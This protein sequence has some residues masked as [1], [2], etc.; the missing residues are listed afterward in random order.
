MNWINEALEAVKKL[1]L[2]FSG[3]IELHWNIDDM[4]ERY[5]EGDDGVRRY[6]SDRLYSYLWASKLSGGQWGTRVMI[7]LSPDEK[8]LFVMVD[9]Y[10]PWGTGEEEPYKIATYPVG[11]I[12]QAF[13]LAFAAKESDFELCGL[14]EDEDS[15]RYVP[16]PI[17]LPDVNLLLAEQAISA[18]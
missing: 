7:A 6:Y 4:S 16:A 15:G 8:S 10:Q 3:A 13:K 12:Y 11:E 14:M 17:R 1:S 5:V 18:H 9:E 2:Y